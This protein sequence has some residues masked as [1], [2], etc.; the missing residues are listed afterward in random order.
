[1]YFVRGMRGTTVIPKVRSLMQLSR[2]DTEY[3]YRHILR[4]KIRTA[5]KAY[6]YIT[7]F[8][9]LHLLSHWP[10]PPQTTTHISHNPHRPA[11]PPL[12]AREHLVDLTTTQTLKTTALYTATDTTHIPLGQPLPRDPALQSTNLHR[13]RV[14]RRADPRPRRHRRRASGV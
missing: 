9:S 14:P 10:P 5:E 6:T 4:V 3:P 13:H 7:N 11:H 8:S 12:R 2:Q 1:M